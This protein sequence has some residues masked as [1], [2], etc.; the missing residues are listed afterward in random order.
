M[1][2]NLGE[3]PLRI[4]QG[5]PMRGRDSAARMPRGRE[6]AARLLL[7]SLFPQSSSAFSLRVDDGG[8]GGGYVKIN[9]E[10]RREERHVRRA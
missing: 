3:G 1:A 10:R 4:R 7:D 2:S 9:F 5:T 8:G 6:L